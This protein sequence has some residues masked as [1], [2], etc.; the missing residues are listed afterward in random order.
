MSRQAARYSASLRLFTFLFFKS[1][2][3]RAVARPPT[4]QKLWKRRTL[5]I[6][7]STSLI[8]KKAQC[9]KNGTRLKVVDNPSPT[10]DETPPLRPSLDPPIRRSSP[11]RGRRQGGEGFSGT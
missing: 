11:T 9:P 4:A 1:H 3:L 6:Y 10:I 7:F 5:S 2:P 8:V